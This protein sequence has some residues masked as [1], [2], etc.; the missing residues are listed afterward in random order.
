MEVSSS[1]MIGVEQWRA[2][3][4]LYHPRSHRQ[5]SRTPRERQTDTNFFLPPGSDNYVNANFDRAGAL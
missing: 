3:I 1:P 4:G 5:L 2:G